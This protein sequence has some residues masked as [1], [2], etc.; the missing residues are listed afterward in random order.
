MVIF[1]N[2]PEN[3]E[4]LELAKFRHSV[5]GLEENSSYKSAQLFHF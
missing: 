1:L 3:Q 2:V 4:L 5:E